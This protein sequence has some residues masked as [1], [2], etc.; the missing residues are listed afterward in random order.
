MTVAAR[1]CSNAVGKAQ[2]A[3]I[4][5]IDIDLLNF[6]YNVI[7]KRTTAARLPYNVDGMALLAFINPM[8]LTFY[9][10]GVL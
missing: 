3:F 2:S 6:R 7:N 5:P 9:I 8:T 4:K 10:S 1:L